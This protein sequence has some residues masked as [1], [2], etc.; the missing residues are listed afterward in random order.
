[1]RMRRGRCRPNL[2][3]LVRTFAQELTSHMKPKERTMLPMQ[4]QLSSTRKADTTT[5]TRRRSTT[6]K[7]CRLGEEGGGTGCAVGGL[8]LT[9]IGYAMAWGRVGQDFKRKIRKW[10]SWTGTAKS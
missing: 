3:V 5:R 4:T 8:C 10:K 2:C 1:M 6:S 7:L 9:L